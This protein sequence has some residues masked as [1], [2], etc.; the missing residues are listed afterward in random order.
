MGEETLGCAICGGWSWDCSCWDAREGVKSLR[1][2]VVSKCNCVSA[3]GVGGSSKC[4]GSSTLRVRGGTFCKGGVSFGVC[5]NALCGSH[6]LGRFFQRACARPVSL[7]M[8]C[9]SRGY[10]VVAL[11]MD[12]LG[13]SHV[14]TSFHMDCYP[15]SLVGQALHMSANGLTRCSCGCN[16]SLL[17]DVKDVS[18]SLNV[19]GRAIHY[20]SRISLGVGVV[21]MGF[22][23]RS[24]CMGLVSVCLCCLSLSVG[25]Q[26][27][28]LSSPSFSVSTIL[29][30]G[31][32]SL[33]V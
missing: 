17:V 29:S 24:L 13:I 9:L 23:L 12:G 30:G 1:V 14:S 7:C 31:F 8:C 28:R 10:V 25:I 2:G 16:L 32:P 4:L 26:S 18:I 11:N 21:R 27:Q 20:L 19:R 15:R 3:L 22:G 5:V 33:S 6:I